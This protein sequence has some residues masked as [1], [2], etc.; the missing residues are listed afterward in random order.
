MSGRKRQAA[1]EADGYG[2]QQLEADRCNRGAVAEA[3]AIAGDSS[4]AQRAVW[5]R[6]SHVGE[7][8]GSS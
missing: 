3:D 8:G 4:S 1:A 5:R 7:Q 6:N 2:E